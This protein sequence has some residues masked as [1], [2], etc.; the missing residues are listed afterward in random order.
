MSRAIAARGFGLL[1]AVVAGMALAGCARS[2]ANMAATQPEA[3]DLSILSK[4][5]HRDKVIARIGAPELSTPHGDMTVDVYKFVQG[6]SAGAR[7][8]RVFAH[9][10]LSIATLG[11]WEVAGTAIEGYARG[12][13][14]SIRVVYDKQGLLQTATVLD[15]EDTISDEIPANQDATKEPQRQEHTVA[16]GPMPPL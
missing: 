13:E 3:K 2:A 16:S 5:T 8:A 7:T 4:G 12:N 10:T 9:S 1:L 6:Y 15:G 14:V 11:L